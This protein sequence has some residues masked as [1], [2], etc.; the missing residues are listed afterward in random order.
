M[1][2]TQPINRTRWLFNPFIYLGGE[3]ALLTGIF[4][5]FIT[6]VVAYFSHAHL[7][8]V[9][10]LHIGTPSSYWV[11][12]AESMMDWAA[13]VVVFYPLSLVLSKSKIRLIDIAGTMALARLPMFFGVV[14]AFLPPL[15]GLP[16]GQ[17]STLAIA[18]SFLILI[19]VIWL[20][21]LMY[22]AFTISANLKG[23]RAVFGFIGGLLAAEILSKVLI[24]YLIILYLS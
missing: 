14:I 21:T 20:V 10:D 6:S 17:I 7:D 19:P 1:N 4:G 16:G 8:G 18:C 3:I 12:A 9:L 11:F 15:Q 23:N 22:H 2:N 5:M 24:G 13:V